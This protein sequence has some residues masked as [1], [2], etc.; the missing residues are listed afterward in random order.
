MPCPSRCAGVWWFAIGDREQAPEEYVT[1][2]SNM[3]VGRARPGFD[4]VGSDMRPAN[5]DRTCQEE[6]LT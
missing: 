3:Q 4:G 6:V 1:A 5:Q 2:Q